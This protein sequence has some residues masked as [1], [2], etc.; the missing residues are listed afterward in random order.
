M[1]GDTL[2]FPDR[3]RLRDMTFKQG[4]NAYRD[5]DQLADAY[6]NEIIDAF[7]DLIRGDTDLKSVKLLIYRAEYACYLRGYRDRGTE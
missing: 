5:L 1:R 2:Q 7:S 3:R 4:C 6:S